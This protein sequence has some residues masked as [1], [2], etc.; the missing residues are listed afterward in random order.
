MNITKEEKKEIEKM[1]L[2]WGK[3]KAEFYYT[4]RG[5]FIDRKINCNDAYKILGLKKFWKGMTIALCKTMS[6]VNINDNAYIT[7]QKSRYNKNKYLVF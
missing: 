4:K 5:Y 7:I 2:G 1:L 6:F 3:A